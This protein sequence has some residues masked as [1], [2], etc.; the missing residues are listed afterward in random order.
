[1]AGHNTD[2]CSFCGRTSKE[3]NVLLEGLSGKICD[4]CVQ[5]A[6]TMLPNLT[7]EKKEKENPDST[8]SFRHQRKSSNIWTNT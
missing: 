8:Q 4:V 3:C 7:A 2:R 6:Y 5:Q 1:M